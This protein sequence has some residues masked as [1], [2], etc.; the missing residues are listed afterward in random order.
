[1]QQVVEVFGRGGGGFAQQPLGERRERLRAW[2][3][4]D[5]DQHPPGQ[6]HAHLVAHQV[7]GVHGEAQPMHHQ[8]NHLAKGIHPRRLGGVEHQRCKHLRHIT[9]RQD[10]G[11]AVGLADAADANPQGCARRHQ[12]LQLLQAELAVQHAALGLHRHRRQRGVGAAIRQV[13]AGGHLPRPVLQ[14]AGVQRS[15]GG[16]QLRQALHGFH[17]ACQTLGSVAR[18]HNVWLLT[19][20]WCC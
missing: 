8:G 17:P 13:E 7:E 20:P 6:H 14:P 9:G 12:A 1:M 2:G 4:F 18:R 10:G 5:G 3:L 15:R 16:P 19:C 11:D